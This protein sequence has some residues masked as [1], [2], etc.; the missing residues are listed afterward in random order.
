MTRPKA[1][2]MTAEAKAGELKLFKLLTT[3]SIKES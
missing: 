2:N 3:L 1:P